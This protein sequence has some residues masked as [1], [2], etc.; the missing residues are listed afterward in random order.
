MEFKFLIVKRI[1]MR[2]SKS[3]MAQTVKFG[4]QQIK[5]P[6]VHGITMGESEPW[7]VDVLERLNKAAPGGLLDVG[8]NLGQTLAAFKIHAPDAPYIG[9]EPNP[10]CV[11]YAN[12]LIKENGFR[13]CAI[14]PAALARERGLIAL[15]FYQDTDIDSSAS[16]IPNFRS[17]RKVM[18]RETICTIDGETLLAHGG[19]EAVSIVK[20]DVE[21]A[22]AQVIAELEP[23]LT[24]TRAVVVV[25]VLPAYTEDNRDRVS[26]QESIEA[27]LKRLGYDIF[28]LNHDA[29]KFHSASKID[30]FGIYDKIE[31]ADHI[32]CPSER[33]DEIA[34]L[35]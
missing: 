4:D 11:N 1:K 15:E 6:I 16:I 24:Q 18:R 7:M 3:L 28:R 14:I 13:N 30:T 20:I 29:V 26:S 27:I 9:L 22:E 8:V 21:G 35:F 33:S 19:T 10:T 2:V 23:L 31:M 32:L 25:E 17:D 5:L 34:K 12:L